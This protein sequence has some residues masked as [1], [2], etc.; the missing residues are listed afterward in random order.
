[1]KLT[2]VSFQENGEERCRIKNIH[3]QIN[4][5]ELVIIVGESGAGKTTL[6]KLITGCINRLM[7]VLLITVIKLV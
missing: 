4:P 6:L 2:N 7:V 3:L 1:M 5:G